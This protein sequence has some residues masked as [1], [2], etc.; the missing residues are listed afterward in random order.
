MCN[1]GALNI[2]SNQA[3]YYEPGRVLNSPPLGAK[4]N[5]PIIRT[6]KKDVMG[7][8]VKD[9]KWSK[10]GKSGANSQKVREQKTLPQIILK[11]Q[12][13]TTIGN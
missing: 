2:L 5:M 13:H 1:K 10:F 11:Q 3:N 9:E 8:K 7:P 12:L 6:C 4:C